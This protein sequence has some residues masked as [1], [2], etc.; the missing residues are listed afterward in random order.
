MRKHR[1]CNPH[2]F[3]ES[4]E[5]FSWC[6]S[7]ANKHANWKFYQHPRR[8][9]NQMPIKPET[10]KRLVDV[11]QRVNWAK[12]RGIFATAVS[13]QYPRGG[14]PGSLLYVGICSGPKCKKLGCCDDQTESSRATLTWMTDEDY[15]SAFW[16]FVEKIESNTR[17]IAWTNI[18]KMDHENGRNP[19][20][21][22]FDQV[23]DESMAALKEEMDYLKPHVTLFV[24]NRRYSHRMN[25]LLNDLEFSPCRK[26]WWG[27]W[28]RLFQSP[29]GRFI[30]ITRHPSRWGRTEERTRVIDRV[31]DLMRPKLASR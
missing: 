13:L 14:Q 31:K 27:H 29:Q 26:D 22:E 25:R 6:H 16:T 4:E 15:R 3:A 23:A 9:M 10:W 20:S 28:L 21:G 17:K 8:A 5:K 7:D 1:V 2:F 18:C 24:I 11:K 19:T 30:V 12:H